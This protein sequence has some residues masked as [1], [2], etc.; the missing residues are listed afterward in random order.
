MR[1]LIHGGLVIDPSQNLEAVRDVL[2]E[3]G[4]IAD[5]AR[6]LASRPGLAGVRRLDARGCWVLPGIMDLHVHLREPGGEESETLASGARAA[7]AGGV[8][9]VLAMPNTSP[10]ADSPSRLRSLYSK[11]RRD[12]PVHVFF[13]AA[14]TRGQAGEE[15]SDLAAL[16][17]A[18]AA[19]FSDDGRPVMNAEPLRQALLASKRLGLS[20]LDHAEDENLTGP[21]ILHE[22]AA[23]RFGVAGIPSA[24]EVLMALRDILLAALTGG[25]LHLCHVSCAETV[26]LLRAAKRRGLA[27]SAEAT[28]H[29]F[30]LTE[31]DIPARS[32]ADY[33]MKPPLMARSDREAVLEGLADGT[34]DAIATDHAPHAPRKKALGLKRAP[35]GVI[36]L[37]T[38]L[39]LSLALVEKGRLSR[40]SLVER[41]C[42]APARI[43]GLKAKG[44]L[45]RFAD[46]DLSV[47]EPETGFLV[48]GDFVSRS[49]NSPFIGRRLK[50]RA[51]AAVVSGRIAY[52]RPNFP[53]VAGL[54]VPNIQTALVWDV[55]KL[56]RSVVRDVSNQHRMERS[57]RSE[58]KP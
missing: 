50:G 19:D 39:P 44:H 8:T 26:R 54:D 34:L 25:R 1:L 46:A 48:T 57:I 33:K 56:R 43:L 3:N 20:V 47:V 37:E 58:A 31:E 11:S 15:L 23:R 6:G 36:G 21:G 7:A 42:A 30:T 16:A 52:L 22:R 27:V 32:P 5:V 29:H 28:P 35:F 10:P 9:T 4:K 40:R 55:P 17:E 51:R 49:R 38:L 24:S 53:N 45:R 12:C 14:L 2:I 41:L 13:A 18:G